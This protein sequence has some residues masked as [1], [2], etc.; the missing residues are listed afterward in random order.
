MIIMKKEVYEYQGIQYRILKVEDSRVIW[1]DIKDRKPKEKK[2]FPEPFCI[3]EFSDLLDSKDIKLI[4]DNYK[5][6]ALIRKPS[7][8]EQV[9]LRDKRY[10][11]IE[12]LLTHPQFYL[13]RVRGQIIKEIT[14]K[15]GLRFDKV[16]KYARQ[17][18]QRGCIKNALLPN[19]QNCGLKGKRKVYTKKPG[20]ESTKKVSSE[21]IIDD[22]IGEIIDS[23][24]STWYLNRHSTFK[25]AYRKFIK[26]FHKALPEVSSKKRPSQRQVKRYFQSL[27]PLVDIVKQRTNKPDWDKDFRPLKSV[28][29]SGVPGPGARYEL[30]ATIADIYIVSDHDRNKIIGRPTIYLV[31]DTYSRFVAGYYIGLEPPSYKASMLAIMSAVTDKKIQRCHELGFT[32]VTKENFP[33]F[34][35]PESI[36]VDRGELM[37]HQLDFLCE[38]N[39]IKILTPPP[40]RGDA[41]GIVERYFHI[42][43]SGFK[44]V[45]DG[46]VTG[47]KVK[48][49][50]GKDY[51]STANLTMEDF[52]RIIVGGIIKHNQFKPLKRNSKDPQLQQDLR[53]TPLN[54]WIWGQKNRAGYMTA[55]DEDT[56][57]LALLPHEDAT[58]S[59]RQICLRGIYY[60]CEE[61]E[62]LGWFHR[63]NTVKRPK[64]IRVAYDPRRMNSIYVLPS[65]HNETFL[66]ANIS[67]YSSECQ[68]QSLSEV[69]KTRADQAPLD[70]ETEEE[71]EAELQEYYD[72]VEGYV[73]EAREKQKPS[74]LSD[75][76]R[77]KGIR[78]NKA[79]ALKQERMDN[80]IKLSPPLGNPI[81]ENLSTDLQDED[82]GNQDVLKALQQKEL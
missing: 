35:L 40:Y 15:Y 10:Q 42:F 34:G 50:G 43:Q 55:V 72:Q 3:D 51:R 47:T 75:T 80:A 20:R 28:A 76:Q 73:K 19:F 21:A 77:L 61:F 79:E 13:P 82:Y 56:L 18:W 38:Q 63:K 52:E 9:E 22:F 24:I 5:Y 62:E 70:E 64:T 14:E 78:D 45:A 31:V 41:K 26:A 25:D 54:L 33:P 53:L 58:L 16:M 6:L 36:M 29:T 12:S 71:Y 2:A 27:Y 68:D 32:K 60:N 57:T 37:G 23:E 30:D 67:E 44:R 39:F 49:H 7:E 46:V 17:F 59:D 74:K 11:K 4:E 48:K 1:F 81:L 8:D 66:V 69:L 65:E